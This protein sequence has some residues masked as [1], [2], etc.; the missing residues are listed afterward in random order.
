MKQNLAPPIIALH[1]SP[2]QTRVSA[3]LGMGILENLTVHHM[4]CHSPLFGHQV[5]IEGRWRLGG[6]R[7]GVSRK[8]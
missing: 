4:T 1:F 5:Q 8:I 6:G 2:K 7:C 3:V